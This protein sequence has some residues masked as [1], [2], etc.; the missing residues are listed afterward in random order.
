MRAKRNGNHRETALVTGGSG[1]I[2]LELAKV[3]ARNG[4]DLVLVSRTRDS[5]EAAAGQIEGKY[6]VKVHVFA[7]DLR[8]REAPEAI[9]D[10]LVMILRYQWRVS[11][12]VGFLREPY[13]PFEFTLATVDPGTDPA[14]LSIE[15]PEKLSR[16]LI[17]FKW[18]LAIPHYIVLIFVGI[19]AVFAWLAAFVVVLVTGRW[20]DGLRR[21]VVGVSRWINRV[22]AYVGLLTDEYPPFSLS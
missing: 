21:F 2:G 1:G 5:L 17:F 20:P 9:F 19:A 22:Y 6:D 16:V 11:S 8:R 13:A 18:F 3:L 4:F 10:F 15:R 14:R 7:A 12:Y